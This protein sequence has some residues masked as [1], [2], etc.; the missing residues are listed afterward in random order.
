M[1]PPLLQ[2]T[3]IA[4][5]FGGTSL[6]AGVDLAVGAGERICLVGRN[7]SGKSTLLR[8]AAGL[9]QPDSGRRFVQPGA[10]VRYLPQEPDL[11]AYPTTLAYVEA[12]LS[13]SDDPHRARH[14]LEDLGLTGDEDPAKLS[15]GEA[16]RAALAHVL[17]P[18]PQI[19]LLDEPTNHLDLPAIEWLEDR[20]AQSRAALVLIS[21]D[22]RFLETLSRTTVWLDRGKARRVELPF[23][24]FEDWRD[25]ELADEEVRQH[26]LDRKIVAE[27]HWVHGGVTAR[28]KRNVRRMA[29]L[30]KLRQQ[31]RDYRAVQGKA[32][33]SVAEA[34]TSSGLV[35]EAKGIS[36]SFG[37]RAVV[38]DLSLRVM[39]GDRLGIVGP[40]GSGKTTLASLLT[41][42]LAPDAGEV[43]LGASVEMAALDQGRE[44]LDPTWTLSEALTRGRG[45]TVA[46][47]GQRK[48]VVAYMKDFLFAPEQRL[49]PIRALSGGER[50]RLMLARA[51]ATPSNLLVLDEPTNDLDLETLDVLEEVLADYKGT[52]LL[53]SHDR[54]FLDRVVTGVLVPEGD[55]RWTEYAG[56]Y[57]DMLAQRGADLAR[58]GPRPK[59]VAPQDK[60]AK[61]GEAAPPA[62]ARRRLS[63]K[64]KH[65][66]ETLPA[67][68]AALEA[69]QA[70]LTR[71]LD[72]PDLYARDR[73][74]FTELSNA[75]AD[76]QGKLTAAEER[77][78]ELELLRSEIEG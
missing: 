27:E 20:L 55:G 22:R 18:D 7:G 9:I 68:I 59:A 13:A 1:A 54:D 37:A 70:A 57:R 50:G 65:A 4:L 26:K 52:V 29:E 31:R 66:L 47:G 6:L 77:W 12:G 72:A 36:K 32:T 28:R 11:S 53:I 39:R 5:T 46:I 73:A 19:L 2:L 35:I 51:L 58:R 41:G 23:S 34:E 49:T 76:V 42:M 21:H 8:I 48:H 63:F 44:S 38:R 25:R 78:L 64:D 17:A 60:A 14:L 10:L 71:Q 43:R 56:G 61:A 45:D 74:R 75:L 24:A 62:A 33:L 40:N 67:E 30:R 15:G 3:D 16:R 69:K